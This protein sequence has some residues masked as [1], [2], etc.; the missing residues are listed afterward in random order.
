MTLVGSAADVLPCSDVR[1]DLPNLR[2]SFE[3][4]QI[5]KRLV[6]LRKGQVDAAKDSSRQSHSASD[7]HCTESGPFAAISRLLDRHLAPSRG[8]I[9]TRIGGWLRLPVH[10]P[11]IS[12]PRGPE[13]ALIIHAIVLKPLMSCFIIGDAA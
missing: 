1:P 3:L 8:R 10:L 12:G 7:T 11:E 6:R 13:A 2:I 5:R 9:N 4:C